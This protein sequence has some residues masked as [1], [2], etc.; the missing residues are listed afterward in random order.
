MNYN[1]AIASALK[2]LGVKEYLAGYD[3]IKTAVRL[4]VTNA[5]QKRE[6][7][8]QLYYAVAK[9]YGMPYTLVERNIRYAIT[10]AFN[11]ADPETLDRWFG[12]TLSEKTGKATNRQFVEA[13]TEAIKQEVE[14]GAE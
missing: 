8:M 9:E 12:N 5:I 3:Y 4:R 7:V 2:E 10:R 1:G 11:C 6:G 13:I 14:D